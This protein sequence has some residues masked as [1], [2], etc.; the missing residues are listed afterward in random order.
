MKGLEGFRTRRIDSCAPIL[1]S[2][3]CILEFHLEH[4]SQGTVALPD[5]GFAARGT[6]FMA[7]EFGAAIDY[8][9]TGKAA[10][11]RCKSAL[12][13]LFAGGSP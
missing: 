4:G 13:R 8:F 6:V 2:A 1:G 3:E 11:S 10:W 12:S 7:Q 5:T 9:S